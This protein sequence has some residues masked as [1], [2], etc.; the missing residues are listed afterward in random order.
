MVELVF[1]LHDGLTLQEGGAEVIVVEEEG[2][3]IGSQLGLHTSKE[4]GL[5]QGQVIFNLT[6]LYARVIGKVTNAILY[7]IFY[8]WK[9]SYE[10]QFLCKLLD[11]YK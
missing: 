11:E 1:F 9:F 2:P 4:D 5:T 3:H 7:F 6:I 8:Y 10:P